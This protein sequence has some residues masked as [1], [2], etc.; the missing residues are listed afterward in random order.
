MQCAESRGFAAELDAPRRARHLLTT[1]L[2]RAEVRGSY[3]DAELVLSELVTHAALHGDSDVIRVDISA[4]DDGRVR[5]V[6]VD[7]DPVA[8]QRQP[9]PRGGL[10]GLSMSI[11]DEVAH[12]WGVEY[13][14][15]TRSVW[16]ELR[17]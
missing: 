3:R 17:L 7:T 2:H 12:D 1:V 6:V 15:D 4:H 10:G 5:L 8:F 11:I 9:A 13:T 14:D 16:A